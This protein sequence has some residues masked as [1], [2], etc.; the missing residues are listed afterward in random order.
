MILVTLHPV[1]DTAEAETPEDAALAARTLWDEAG[2]R[3]IRPCV[4][5]T[6]DGQVAY[7]TTRRSDL[8]ARQS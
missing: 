8:G 1:G 3:C 7:R 2:Q 6:V 4:T 5:F